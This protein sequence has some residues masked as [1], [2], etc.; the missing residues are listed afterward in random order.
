MIFEPVAT[1][2]KHKVK[3]KTFITE[4]MTVTDGLVK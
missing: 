3:L 2:A 1:A 4:A